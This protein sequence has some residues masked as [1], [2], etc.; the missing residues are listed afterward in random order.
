MISLMELS[1]LGVFDIQ[2]GTTSNLTLNATLYHQFQFGVFGMKDNTVCLYV[3]STKYNF[4]FSFVATGKTHRYH[5]MNPIESP[6]DQTHTHTN[7]RIYKQFDMK[8]CAQSHIHH[9]H[10]SYE[11]ASAP[12]FVF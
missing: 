5:T 1:M 3:H 10:H 12:F 11:I 4:I 6:A 8:Y 7:Q 9:Q 2:S